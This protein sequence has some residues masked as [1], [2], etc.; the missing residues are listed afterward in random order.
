MESANRAPEAVATVPITSFIP[1]LLR[2][3]VTGKNTFKNVGILRPNQA[4]GII[5][6]GDY[7]CQTG[8]R[9]SR[10]HATHST[11][12]LTALNTEEV[13]NPIRKVDSIRIA[14]NDYHSA[15]LNG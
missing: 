4:G 3:L 1:L 8:K 5:A 14:S 6:M 11:S 10:G 7:S 12:V 13:K 15:C 2:I 9:G